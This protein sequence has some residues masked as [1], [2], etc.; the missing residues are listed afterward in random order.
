MWESVGE[1]IKVLAEK[2]L[3][4]TV[5][6][7]VLGTVALLITPDDFFVIRKLSNVWYCLFISGCIFLGVE[8][9]VW[10]AGCVSGWKKRRREAK[11]EAM[12]RKLREDALAGEL[13]DYVDGLY[14][15]DRKYLYTFLKNGNNPILTPPVPLGDHRRLLVD[16]TV[17][18]RTRF[19]YN[20]KSGRVERLLCLEEN[21][22]D[23]LVK[24]KKLY[25]KISRFDKENH[26]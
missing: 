2:H 23:E 15:R 14:E 1:T 12:A 19:Y 17:R 13:W 11:Q 8:F 7:L 3:I 18:A 4:P 16:D 25:G 22:Y 9:I 26:G 10:V 21:F 20:E 24:V 6:S 5:L